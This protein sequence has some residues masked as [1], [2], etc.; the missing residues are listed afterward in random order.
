MKNH[1]LTIAGVLLVAH[2]GLKAAEKPKPN[3]LF[4]M[5]DDLR[6]ETGSYGSLAITANLDRLAKMSVQKQRV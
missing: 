1:L 3:V 6:A 5:A 4:M 2:S